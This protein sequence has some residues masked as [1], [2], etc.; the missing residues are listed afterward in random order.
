MNII[1]IGIFATIIICALVGFKRGAIKSVVYVA[2]LLLITI[3]SY[4]FKPVLGSLLIKILPFRDLGGDLTAASSINVLVYQGLAFVL[5]FLALL[6]VLAII[7]KISGILD[8]VVKFTLILE[9]PSKIIGLLIGAIEGVIIAYLLLFTAMQVPGT[10][11]FVVES[12]H[13]ETVL[14]KTPFIHTIFDK[15]NKAAKGIYN[16]IDS[17]AKGEDLNDEEILDELEENG[18]ISKEEIKDLK[19][20]GKV[21]IDNIVKKVKGEK[22]K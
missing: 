5:L 9:I 3:I 18:I 11:R 2:A 15:G 20:K 16:I 7:I 13:G 8:L 4:Q 21:K 19:K 17:K 14:N 1:D 12:R 22:N 6:I 10:Q